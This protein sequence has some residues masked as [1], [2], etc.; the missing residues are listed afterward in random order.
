MSG[1]QQ[2]IFSM[3][4]NEI[5]DRTLILHFSEAGQS[6]KLGQ[7]V[8]SDVEISQPPFV[9]YGQIGKGLDHGSTEEACGLGYSGC[10]CRA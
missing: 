6:I 3:E 7:E 5:R 2:L 9:L 10:L 8:L 1:K 4:L